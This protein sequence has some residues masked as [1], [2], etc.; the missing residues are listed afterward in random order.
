MAAKPLLAG[1]GPTSLDVGT[2]RGVVGSS[3]KPEATIQSSFDLSRKVTLDLTW[4][5]VAALSAFAV[6]SYSTGDA[7]FAWRFSRQFEVAIVG[8]NLLQPFHPEYGHDPGPIV[9]I[10]RSAYLKLTW[11]R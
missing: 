7:R 4:W 10:R 9:A 1:E 8:R 2:A 11:N 3:P 5:Y 6:P